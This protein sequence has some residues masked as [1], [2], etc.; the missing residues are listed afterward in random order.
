M[1]GI[2]V[3][4]K[5]FEAIPSTALYMS[6]VPVTGFSRGWIPLKTVVSVRYFGKGNNLPLLRGGDSRVG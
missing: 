1:S 2:S 3:E 5:G 6:F 4:Y